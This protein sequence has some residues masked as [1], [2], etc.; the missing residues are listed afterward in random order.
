MSGQTI[1]LIT[2]SSRWCSLS[3]TSG[4]RSA[5]VYNEV[6]WLGRRARRRIRTGSKALIE[7]LREDDGQD[8]LEYA[9][10]AAFVGLAGLV[11]L[12]LFAGVVGAVYT[13][14]DAGVQGLWEP[15]DPIG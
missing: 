4:C 10:L 3:S 13:G 8:L 12:Q 1:A 9:L 7:L 15:N 11:V 6:E 2:L 5:L 14:W